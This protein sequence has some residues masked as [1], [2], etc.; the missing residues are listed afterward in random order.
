MCNTLI[1]GHVINSQAD[2]QLLTAGLVFLLC[3]DNIYSSELNRNW[4]HIHNILEKDILAL[5]KSI[6]LGHIKRNFQNYY[7]LAILLVI[8]QLAG[9]SP[10]RY[11]K[12]TLTYNELKDIDIQLTIDKLKTTDVDGTPNIFLYFN[13]V[14]NNRSNNKVFF[15]PNK[16]RIKAN[17]I[18][19][20]AT[21]Y[22]ESMGSA[23][24]EEIELAEGTSSYYLY[25]VYTDTSL[26][27]GI[28][29]EY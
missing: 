27:D 8:S 29:T 9:C 11:P 1:N 24:T 20:T 15:D 18:T 25:A 22:G 2:I 12:D 10:G 7:F 19:N 17:G 26:T 23:V 28:N 4:L 13:Y 16:L 5:N 3:F 6:P 21:Y 14:I